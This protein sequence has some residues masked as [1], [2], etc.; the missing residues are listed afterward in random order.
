MQ[1]QPQKNERP[2]RQTP[3][4]SKHAVQAIALIGAV[5]IAASFF[6]QYRLLPTIDTAT[7]TF[8]QSSGAVASATGVRINEIM[9]KNES[10]IP[11]ATGQYRDYI[12]LIN[13]GDQSA[14]LTGFMLADRAKPTAESL[15]TFPAQTLAP[16]E[17]V[18]VFAA[19]ELQ[20]YAGS[21]Y[22]APFKISSAGEEVFLFDATGATADQVAVPALDANTC[23]ARDASTGE[24]AIT[25]DYTPRFANTGENHQTLVAAIPTE[26]SDLVISE[27]MSDNA[28]YAL[29]SDGGRHDY[30]ELHNTGTS[31]IRLSGYAM[32]DDPAKPSKWRF[33]DATIGAGQYLLVLMTGEGTEVS[34]SPSANFKLDSAGEE[35]L[36]YNDRAQLI[37]RVSFGALGHDVAYSMTDEGSYVATLKPT[38]GYAN[39]DDGARAIDASLRAAN[40]QGLFISEVVSSTRVANVNE[41]SLDWIELYNA[42]AN[43]ISLSGWGLSDKPSRPRKWT[44][45]D[46][47]SIG[48]GEY[49][50]IYASGT[51]KVNANKGIYTTNF[52]LGAGNDETLTLCMPDGSIVDRVPL[53]EQ[54]GE[55]AYGRVDGNGELAYFSDLTPSAPN[56]SQHYQGRAP[57]V[58]YSHVGGIVTEESITVSLIAPEGYEIYYTTDCTDPTKSSNR[59]RDPLLVNATT[60]LRAIA[61]KDGYLA[62]YPA[63]VTYLFG[64]SHTLPVACVVTDPENLW[65]DE[66]GIYVMGPNATSKFPY[67]S[68]NHGANFWMRWERAAGRLSDRIGP[69]L[70]TVAGMLC[71]AAGA[72]LTGTLTPASALHRTLGSV[73][74]IGLGAGLFTA[75]NNSAIMGAAPGARQGVAGALLAA[76]R[77]LGFAFGV[78]LAGLVFTLEPR[79]HPGLPAPQVVQ[80]GFHAGMHMVGALAL[81]AAALCLARG[82]RI[83]VKG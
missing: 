60:V 33:P 74:L 61:L 16:G 47:V 72:F 71:M 49:K 46:G 63:S 53:G 7:P 67:G 6:A 17:M 3:I 42:S 48:P 54:Y 5:A 70:P 14:D 45:P 22:R 1:I 44:F 82:R 51:G 30:V 12:E 40:S 26:R 41:E 29:G 8:S 18:V 75:P 80:A 21:E 68:I 35:I 31:D 55:I 15:F 77:T 69:R 76:A 64:V 39:D 2:A 11:D 81:L 38:P 52:K 73:L 13:D 9:S 66:K 79:L 65:S 56:S 19:G 24:W 20:N 10:A 83:G 50:V 4:W 34:G 36:L 27:L 43:T 78:A 58:T 23:Y 59:Y 28:T 32:T 37:G 57:K 25:G 62:S